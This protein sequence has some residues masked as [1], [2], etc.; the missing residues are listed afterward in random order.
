MKKRRKIK[1]SG[2]AVC[3]AA[4][5][6]SGCTE[7]KESP[8]YTNLTDKDTQKEVCAE[9]EKHGVTKEQTDTLVK[10]ADDF[11][12]RVTGFSFQDGFQP[13][14]KE[15]VDYTNLVLEN[16]ETED[17]E[18]VPEANCRLTSFLLMKNKIHTE[19]SQLE[20]DTYLMFDIE[21]IDLYDQFK[22][23]PEEKADYI[24]LFNWVPLEGADTEE[25]HLEKIEKTWKDRE[26]QIEG[27]GISLISVYLHSPLEDIRFIGHTGVL[28]ETE[29]GLLFAE[30]YGPLYPFQAVKFADR[31]ELKEYLLGRPDLYGD[32]TEL[33][34]I[35][36][37]ND[38]VMKTS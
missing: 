28:L 19:K 8:V 29:E 9:L 25:E 21:A 31:E 11:N 30:K 15:G 14:E 16:R 1:L 24:C 32:E 12:G 5:L 2:A 38:K 20:D 34:P 26:I 7:Q 10:W 27:D 35:I 3:L 23:S 13:L 18:Y 37:E 17:G 6:L 4:I 36:M 22:M 33:E